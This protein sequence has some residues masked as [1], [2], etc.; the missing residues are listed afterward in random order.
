MGQESRYLLAWSSLQGSLWLNSRWCLGQQ[1]HP[2]PKVFFQ[3]H[4]VGRIQFLVNWIQ[5]WS[6]L[7]SKP[8][9]FEQLWGDTPCPRAKGKPQQDS[10]RG[11]ITFRIKPQTHQRCSE[12][13]NKPC[14]HQ[15]PKIPQRLRQNCVWVSPVEVWVSRPGYGISPL[16]GGHH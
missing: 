3:A 13:S 15:D 11:K 12:G 2:K 5:E 6:N 1:S 9:Y 14:V 10:R 8:E 4:V 7:S 16:G